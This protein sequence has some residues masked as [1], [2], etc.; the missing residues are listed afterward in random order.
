M[1]SNAHGL[2]LH[3]TFAS[4]QRAAQVVSHGAAVY[5]AG[6][7]GRSG[8]ISPELLHQSCRQDTSHK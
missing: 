7:G 4:L 1:V 8:S 3:M 5:K 6:L 2:I